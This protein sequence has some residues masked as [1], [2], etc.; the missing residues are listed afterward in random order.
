[1]GKNKKKKRL[2]GGKG[3]HGNATK[4]VVLFQHGLTDDSSGVCLNEP[5]NSLAFWLADQGYDVWLGNNRGNGISMTNTRFT[6]N[7]DGFWDFSWAEMGLYDLP[8]EI[9][10]VLAKTG[11][12][13]LSY[14]GHSEGTIQAFA[15]FTSN[16]KVG[17]QTHNI[18]DKV[19]VFVALAPIAYVKNVEVAI[20]Q[21]M[22]TFSIEKIISLLGFRE[23]WIPTAIHKI[24]PGACWLFSYICE[25]VLMALSGPFPGIQ[26]NKLSFWLQYQPNPTSVKNMAHWSQ[27]VRDGTFGMYDYGANG[28]MQKYGQRFPPQFNLTNWPSQLPVALFAGSKDYLSDTKDV[29]TLISLLPKPFVHYETNFGHLDFILGSY[30]NKIFPHVLQ[31]IQ[32]YNKGYH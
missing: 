23:F 26:R 2:P 18:A 29:Q 31:Y 6:A 30:T 7:Q 10:Y 21:V 27:G 11:A 9:E 5:S 13:K 3:N 32:T 15:A 8:A 20:L 16:N 19:N 1:M 12:R 17:W 14:I 28:N 24:L 25:F 4:G 22:A